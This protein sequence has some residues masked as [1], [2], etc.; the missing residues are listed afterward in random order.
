[1]EYKLQLLSEFSSKIVSLMLK[2]ELTSRK[3][4]LLLF[5]SRLLAALIVSALS[6]SKEWSTPLLKTAEAMEVAARCCLK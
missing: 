3:Y 1:L 5:N 6:L 2:K 4:R